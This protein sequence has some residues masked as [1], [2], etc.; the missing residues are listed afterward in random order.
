MK[1]L[2]I[3]FF[4]SIVFLIKIPK[5]QCKTIIKKGIYKSTPININQIKFPQ[6]AKRRNYQINNLL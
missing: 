3:N 2:N 5:L 4:S 1:N 6:N